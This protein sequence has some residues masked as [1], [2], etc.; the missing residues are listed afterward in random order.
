MLRLLVIQGQEEQVFALPETD[1]DLGSAPENGIVLRVK[2]VS[3]RHALVRRC[4]GGIEFID[5]GSKNGLLVEGRRVGRAV[6]TPGL[7]LQ[8]GAAWVELE[9]LTSTAA[10][11]ASVIDCLQRTTHTGEVTAC[12]GAKAGNSEASS[13]EAALRLVYHLDF[14]TT[15]TP[16]ERQALV[17]RLR[18]TLGAEAFAS[19]RRRSDIIEILESDGNPLAADEEQLLTSVS[20]ERRAWPPDEVR[21]KRAGT[22][23]VAGRDDYFFGAKFSTESLARE[24]WRKDFLR[25]IAARLVPLQPLRRTRLSEIA[26]VLAATGGNKSETARILGLTRQTIYAAIKQLHSSRH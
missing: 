16:E 14:A 23:L 25:F 24:I 13:P 21:L 26:Q 8:I 9:E 22:F 12:V 11:L 5:Q 7:R 1:C 10:E 3:R 20:S 6:L 18:A 15:K 19:F 4:P 17:A 2:G